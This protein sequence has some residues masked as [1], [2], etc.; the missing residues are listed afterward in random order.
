[1]RTGIELI[2]LAGLALLFSLG[3]DW[4]KKPKVLYH[5]DY[6]TDTVYIDRLIPAPTVADPVPPE[7]VVLQPKDSTLRVEAE[8]GP[9][10]RGIQF[11]NDKLE[12][13]SISSKGV[14]QLAEY[15]EL[16]YSLPIKI[17]YAGNVEIDE[18]ELK[19]MQ[20][21]EK[22]RRIGNKILIGGSFVAGVLLASV[23]IE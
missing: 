10:L 19:R 20:R 3:M 2:I 15:P 18:K 21:K 6:K 14:S 12:V 1:M 23:V 9:I 17:D 22:L 5:T 13:H 16:P 8:Q 11:K 7:K 4:F